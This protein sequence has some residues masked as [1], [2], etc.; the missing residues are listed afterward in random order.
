MV[1]TSGDTLKASVE[2]AHFGDARLNGVVPAWTLIDA[3]GRA[4]FAGSLPRTD[5]PIGNGVKLGDIRQPLN[6]I[7]TPR[8]LTLCVTVGKHENRW[9]IWVYPASL[10]DIGTTVLVTQSLDDAAVALLKNGGKVLLT[11]KKGSVQADKGGN[12]AIGFSSI[13]WNTSWTNNQPPHTLG[14]LCDPAHKALAEFPT[15]YHSNWQW[16]DAMSHSNAIVLSDLP[17]EVH[18]IVRVIDDWFT[19]RPLAL[20]FEAKVGKG[21]LLVSGIDLLSDSEQRPEARQLLFSVKKYMEGSGF[22]PRTVVAMEKIQ[23]LFK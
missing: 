3:K 10:P 11:V 16:H 15:E 21:R 2:I 17:A 4:V 8:K 1:Y 19:N 12:I 22:N 13:F 14:I 23:G 9:D 18:P 6:G 5:I 20:I 7:D